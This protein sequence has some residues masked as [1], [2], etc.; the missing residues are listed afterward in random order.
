M[1]TCFGFRLRYLLYFA[2]IAAGFVLVDKYNEHTAVEPKEV[3]PALSSERSPVTGMEDRK[4]GAPALVEGVICLDIDDGEPLLPKHRF[5]RNVDFLFC[6]TRFIN[7]NPVDSLKH[8]WIHGDRVVASRVL[9]TDN[10]CRGWSKME[11][12][13]ASEG[14]WRVDVVEGTGSLLGSIPFFLE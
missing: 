6:Y 7:V 3:I 10:R 9:V 13:P 2:I 14:D 1:K 11:I 8:I 12:L 5:S 4:N